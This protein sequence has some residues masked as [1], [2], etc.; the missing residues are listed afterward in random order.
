MEQQN[1]GNQAGSTVDP[2][3]AAFLASLS[4]EQRAKLLERA[5]KAKPTRLG[6]EYYLDKYA[7]ESR[8]SIVP[9]TLHFV[10]TERKQAVQVEC[11]C[12]VKFDRFTSDLHTLVGC[13]KCYAA[14]KRDSGKVRRLRLKAAAELLRQQEEG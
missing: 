4:P 12:G 7:D 2:D 14:H 6:E 3:V 11:A 1:L 8:W 10:E 9:G 13:P 5:S